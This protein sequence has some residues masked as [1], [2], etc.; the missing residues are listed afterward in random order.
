MK[1]LARTIRNNHAFS[2]A[3]MVVAVLLFMILIAGIYTT[4]FVGDAF[5]QVNKVR[6]ALQQE[7]RKGMEWMIH[8]LREAGDISIVDVPADGVWYDAITFKVPSGVSGGVTVWGD[9]I[10]FELDETAT[11]LERAQSGVTKTIARN[12]ESVQFR[13]LAASP[14]I[15][16]VVLSAQ[17]STPRGETIDYQLTFEVQLRN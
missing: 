15:L 4:G 12:I 9:D 3:E 14:D 7:V 6:V 8:D 2:L 10:V 16:E 17:E 5:W 13:R 11:A 1:D